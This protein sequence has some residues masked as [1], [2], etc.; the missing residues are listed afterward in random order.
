MSTPTDLKSLGNEAFRFKN[1]DKAISYYTQALDLDSKDSIFTNNLLLSD[2]S[3]L[4]SNRS[5]CHSIKG[6]FELALEDAEE[7]TRLNHKFAKGYTRKGHAC[8]QLK[9]YK[10]SVKAYRR[11]HQLEPESE[12]IKAYLEEANQQLTKHEEIQAA[13][14]Y[15]VYGNVAYKK[16]DFSKAMT[17]FDEAIKNDFTNLLYYSNKAAVYIETK[18][19]EKVLCLVEQGMRVFENL[20]FAKKNPNNLAKQISRGARAK[21][22]MGKLECAMSLYKEALNLEREPTILKDYME[23]KNLKRFSDT[24]E[25]ERYIMAGSEKGHIYLFDITQKLPIKTDVLFEHQICSIQTLKKTTQVLVFYCKDHEV[26]LI[27][28]SIENWKSVKAKTADGLTTDYHKDYELK[29]VRDYGQVFEE[30]ELRENKCVSMLTPDEKFLLATDGCGI[31]KQWSVANNQLELF[32]DY[33]KQFESA[34]FALEISGN[35]LYAGGTDK[36]LSKIN[37]VKQKVEQTFDVGYVIYCI[38]VSPDGRFLFVG[39]FGGRLR[40]YSI[41]NS[42]L[43]K[44]FR[45]NAVKRKYGQQEHYIIRA[46][47]ITPNLKEI[48][49]GDNRGGVDLFSIVQNKFVKKWSEVAKSGIRS[50]RF[51]KDGKFM[52]ANDGSLIKYSMSEGKFVE[53][54][55]RLENNLINTTA[56]IL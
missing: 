50:M 34:V 24:T 3:K 23:L 43:V 29:K 49:I 4:F 53:K 36:L 26:H 20:E 41:K 28:Y 10:E 19:Y 25:P 31:L 55:I 2:R 56:F 14:S 47:A 51:T 37:I 40:M 48:F 39:G 22:L 11:A 33:G 30:I 15:K 9:L 44:D 35:Y 38:K 6:N 7:S 27:Q 8:L 32:K 17:Y 21:W 54:Y 16:K 46:L 52:F 45:V 42:N 13:E 18:E 5:A 1:Y 12:P